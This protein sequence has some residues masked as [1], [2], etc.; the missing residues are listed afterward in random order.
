MRGYLDFLVR[1]L[2]QIEGISNIFLFGSYLKYHE[3]ANDIDLVLQS[4]HVNPRI[5]AERI[6]KLMNRKG[7][8]IRILLNGYEKTPI[9]AFH[10]DLVVTSGKFLTT[11]ERRGESFIKL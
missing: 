1:E 8:P 3:K 5:M 6:Q 4:R 11:L 9:P 10:V 7:V 2:R